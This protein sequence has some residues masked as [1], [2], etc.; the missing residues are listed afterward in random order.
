MPFFFS[1]STFLNAF[2]KT[3]NNNYNDIIICKPSM[4]KLTQT[5]QKI[6]YNHKYWRALME[7]YECFVVRN[8]NKVGFFEL[9]S[10]SISNGKDLR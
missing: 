4:T 3:N 8:D 10:N 5:I 7:I 1:P 6:S 2:N 9:P